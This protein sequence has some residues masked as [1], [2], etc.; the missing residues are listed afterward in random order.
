MPEDR[1]QLAYV[2]ITPYSLLKSRTGGIIGRLLAYAPLRLVGAWMYAPSDEFVD[3]YCQSIADPDMDPSIRAGLVNYV[4]VYFR[5]KN[6]LGI[7]NRTMLLL[8]KGK[9]AIRALKDEVV[10]SLASMPHG[11]TI[12]GR[13][14]QD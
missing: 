2:L 3:A 12:R 5:A 10:G 9:D 1:E 4:N 13:Q 8:F 7:T 11:D 6:K 14:G